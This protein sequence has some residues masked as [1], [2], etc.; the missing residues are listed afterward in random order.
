[1]RVIE[2]RNT[3]EK[4]KK[5]RN[6]MSFRTQ[7]TIFAICSHMNTHVVHTNVHTLQEFYFTNST[8]VL[9]F[10]VCPEKFVKFINIIV[11]TQTLKLLEV[12]ITW[13]EHFY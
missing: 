5:M 6:T 11:F 9:S 2:R 13:F 8:S 10:I 3:T 1:M 4:I 12:K 7:L